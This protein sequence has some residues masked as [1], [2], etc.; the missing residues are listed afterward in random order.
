[1]NVAR[2]E[3]CKKLIVA[4][5]ESQDFECRGELAIVVLCHCEGCDGMTRVMIKE[6]NKDRINHERT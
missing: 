4:I 1:M 3:K 6:Y 2:C 5:E